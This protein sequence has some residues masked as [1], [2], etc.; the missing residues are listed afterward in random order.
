MTLAEILADFVHGLRCRPLAGQVERE[1]LRVVLDWLGSAIRGGEVTPAQAI[2][3]VVQRRMGGDSATVLSTGTRVSTLGAAL[4]NGAASHALELDDLHHGST[5]HPA[6]PIV[7]AALAAAEQVDADGRLFLQAIVAGYEVGI[8]IAEAANPSHYRFWHPT[9][10]CGVFGAAAAAGCVLG[11]S[12]EELAD[13]LGTAGTLASGLWQFLDEGAM[14][15][16]LHAGKAAHDGL[17]AAELA[18]S[19]LTGAHSILEGRRG[20]FAAT[21]LTAD[22]SRITDGLG[23]RYKILENGYKR[24]ACC[25]HTH[26]AIDGALL[27][28]DR[29]DGRLVDRVEVDTYLVALEITDYPVPKSETEAKFSLQHAV[30]VALI[31]GAAGIEQFR[32]SRL[33]AP[34]VIELRRRVVVREASELTAVYPREWPARVR[35]WLAD[36][37]SLEA[38]VR[39]PRGMPGNPMSDEELRDKFRT[40]VAPVI[41]FDG[42]ERLIEEVERLPAGLPVRALVRSCAS[43]VMAAHGASGRSLPPS[44]A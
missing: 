7:P 43:L 30:A 8:R 28:R 16:P 14:S 19:G 26:T 10:T 27:L 21:T 44:S 15:K 12:S 29:L 3:A 25:G 37:A 13:A 2:H 36:G 4:A 42:V 23:T 24:H 38:M 5:F 20:F 17:L 39:V 31:D 22:S 9:S 41:G 40:L 1:A 35:L 32:S 34:D 11:L 6:A 33:G 18:Q